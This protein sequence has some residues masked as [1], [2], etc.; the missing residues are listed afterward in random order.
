MLNVLDIL[1]P[2]VVTTLLIPQKESGIRMIEEAQR[3]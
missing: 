2:F 1:T 3:A